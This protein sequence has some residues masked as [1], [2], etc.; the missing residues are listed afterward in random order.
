MYDFLDI[1]EILVLYENVWYYQI[2]T[3]INFILYHNKTP[4]FIHDNRCPK[5]NIYLEKLMTRIW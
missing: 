3:T 1:I 2:K 4:H 5:A